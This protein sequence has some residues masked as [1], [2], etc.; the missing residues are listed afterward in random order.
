MIRRTAVIAISGALALGLVGLALLPG[1][2]AET[3]AATT[4]TVALASIASP[5]PDLLKRLDAEVAPPPPRAVEPAVE[6]EPARQAA[7]IEQASLNTGVGLAAPSAE[8]APDPSLQPVTVG[9]SAVN[10]RAGPS[11]GAQQISVLQPGETLQAGESSGGWLKV[12]RADGS[13]G[14]VY[15]TYISGYS[16]GDEQVADTS[17]APATPEVTRPRPPRAVVRGADNGELQDRIARI[18]SRL[19]GY[20]RPSDSAQSIF[21]FAPGDEV[22]IAEVRGSWLR[23]ETEDGFSAWIRR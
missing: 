10:L 9:S 20:S 16:G 3:A 12:T 2:N 6:P 4:K 15:S 5:S 18:G 11:S 23:V 13:S 14:W 1:R 21:T 8:T 22:R 17:P 19:P 7:S